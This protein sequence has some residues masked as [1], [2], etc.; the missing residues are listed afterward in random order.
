MKR[1][2]LGCLLLFGT[3]FVQLASAQLA[4]GSDPAQVADEAVDAWLNT[5]RLDFDTL[6]GLSTEEACRMLPDLLA[7]PPPQQGLEVNLEGQRELDVEEAGVAR[8]SYPAALPSGQAELLTVTLVQPEGAENE[9]TWEATSVGVQTGSQGPS[10]RDRLQT[11]LAGWIFVGF[12]FYILFLLVTPSF[13]RRWLAEGWEVIK[14]HRRIIIGTQVVFY[15]LFGL[16]MLTGANLPQVCTEAVLEV[17][18]AAVTSLGAVEAYGSLNIQR[19]AVITFYQNFG[20]VS[21]SLLFGSSL[22]FGVPAYLIGAMSFYAQGIPFGLVGSIN[23]ANLLF[24][25]VLLVLELTSY[26]LIIGGGGVL[27][28]TIIKGGFGAVR[29]AIR[30]L[31]LMLPFALLFLLAGAW[32]EAV[33]IIL[34]QLLAGQP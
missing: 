28:A 26:F 6:P 23:A 13:F 11:P 7:N 3:A 9:G 15:G 1:L 22:L 16:G 33:L 12:S 5:P 29:E 31:A 10:F 2:L 14:A 24:V 34:P 4:T 32:Y 18:N 21:L 30:K 17:V 20:V 8:F 27:L 25:L 19:A